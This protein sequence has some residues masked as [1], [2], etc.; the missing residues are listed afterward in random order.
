MRRFLPAHRRTGVRLLQI[1]AVQDNFVLRRRICLWREI[2]NWKL[3]IGNQRRKDQISNF[4]FRRSMNASLTQDFNICAVRIEINIG[5]AEGITENSNHVICSAGDVG[6]DL[7]TISIHIN[8]RSVC[9]APV[10][11]EHAV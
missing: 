11:T 5:G 9:K 8:D 1:L 3:E 4:Q 6:S 7:V 10:I 2:G